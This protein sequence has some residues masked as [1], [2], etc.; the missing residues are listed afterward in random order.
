MITTI[1]GTN[2]NKEILNLFKE[3][4]KGNNRDVQQDNNAL[5]TGVDEVNNFC[6]QPRTVDIAIC[7]LKEGIDQINMKSNHI[8]QK[9][10]L[11]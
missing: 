6:T 8:T 10:N 5:I 9:D 7:N 11:I 1:N 3:K 4:C 2:D